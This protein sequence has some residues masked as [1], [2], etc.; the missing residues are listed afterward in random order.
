MTLPLLTLEVRMEPDIVLARQRARQIAGLI[1]FAPLDQTRIA[2]AVSEIA[3]NS[4]LYAG[5][6]RVEFQ[7]NQGPPPG[8]LIRVH[9]RG[10][11]IK[12]L[13]VILSGRY[14][15]PSGMGLGILG[16][17][18]L[19]D[20]FEIDSSEAGS[21][22]TM[23]KILPGQAASFTPKDIARIS[24]ELAHQAPQ[25]LLEELQL[26]NQELLR[27]LQELRERQAEIA[28]LHT[29]EL[30][31]TNRGVVALY[32][33][34]DENAIELRRISDLK[35]RFLS[36]MS[37]EFR[38]PLNTILSMSGFLLDDS[39]SELTS[40]QMK[41]VGF[42]RKAAEDL[43]TLVN[44]LLDLAK[45]EAGKAVIRSE[46]FEVADLFESLRG[47]ITPLL[48]RGTVTL[49]VEEPIGIPTLQTDE[50]KLAQI[51]R[52]FLSNAAK[53]T[54]NGEI[55]LSAKLG[56]GDTI[57]FEVKDTGIGIAPEYQ[58]LV[59]EEFSQVDGPVQ[60]QV[61]GT[62]LGLPLSRKLAELLGGGV[63]VQSQPGVGSTFLA[64]IPRSFRAPEDESMTADSPRE[65]D[66]IR[67]L[68]LVVDDDP[69]DLLLYEKYLAG[70][71]FQVLSARTLGE[72]RSILLRAR[73]LAVLLDILLDT[74]SGWSLLPELKEQPTTSEI[75]ILVLSVVDGKDRAMAL[76]AADF[77]R[78]PID[79]DWLLDRLKRLE[80]SGPLRTI[81][82]ID[83]DEAD[84]YLLKGL[85]IAQGRFVI[86]E[87]TG[88]EEGFRLAREVQPDVIF[89]D[90]VMPEMNGGELLERLKSEDETSNIPV[91]LNTSA[92]LSE[93]E[94]QRIAPGTAAIL[95]KFAET[96]ETAFASIRDALFRAGVLQTQSGT[97]M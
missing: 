65:L 13:Q 22:V 3:R 93:E 24:A 78:K 15:S 44:D 50:G 11:G 1:G 33:E 17:K 35:S 8:F 45:V 32:S 48:A 43:S 9:E 42:I 76:G 82:I 4:F 64:A 68:V 31:E 10:P 54:E 39:S 12:D 67:S 80:K 69:M 72:A 27:T 61:K 66:P 46:A 97:E 92:I 49:V 20:R 57:V 36:N 34:L 14:E 56:P 5:G 53:F 18:R 58:Q 88:G 86:V 38:S 2:T 7:L 75:P 19:M 62:G 84:R 16:A 90:L 95:S 74:E 55:R 73:P 21:T 87:A 59:F 79:R 83:D 41:E 6:G 51:L 91:I 71:G 28:E 52:N 89:L 26:Q 81:L 37:H 96:P 25:G 94:R 47:T 85:L 63:S 40:E 23:V 30:Q 60:R 29:R 70:S 77:Q